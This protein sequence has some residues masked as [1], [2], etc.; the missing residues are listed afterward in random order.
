MTR[1][2]QTERHALCDSLLAAGP[3]APTLSGSWSAA[4]LAAHLVIREGARVDLAA[5]IL[6][7]R[8]SARTD[9]ATR[10]MAERTPFAELVERVRKGPPR[11]HPSRV[12]A[13]DEQMNLVE[14]FI[15]HEDVRR[16]TGGTHPRQLGPGMK[17]A[18]SRRLSMMA[19]L[20]ARGVQDVGVEIVTARVR[21]RVG[22]SGPVVEVHGEPGEVLLYL[23][24]RKTVAQVEFVGEPGAVARLADADLGV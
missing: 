13:V 1:H 21:K 17:D 5:G 14:M 10:R 6:V 8:L 2:A 24:G 9:A 15:H 23:Y 18:L 16:A 4:D 7:P 20:L 12:P 11:W 3:T 19:P 22:G